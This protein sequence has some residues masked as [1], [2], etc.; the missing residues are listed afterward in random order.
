[1]R[2]PTQM[3][4]G[5]AET[6]EQMLIPRVKIGGIVGETDIDKINEVAFELYKEALSIVN[7]AAHLLDDA[8]SV[9]GGWPRNQAIC[10]GLMVRITKF[11]VV[12]TQLSAK[13]DRAEVVS[14]LNRS[15]MES[16]INLEFLVCTK[17][18]KY[19]DQFVK[20]SLGPERELFD[21]IKANVAA[22]G[23]E[24]WPIERRMLK[25][26]NAVCH[27]SGVKIEEVNRKYGDWGGGLRERLKALNKEER[28]VGAQRLPSHA[29]HG[30]WV[31]LYLHHLEHD[32]KTDVFSPDPKFSRVDER[33]LG[34]IAIFVLEATKPYLMRF[35]LEI[36]E[37][38]LLLERIDDMRNRIREVGAVHESL[39]SE[40][41]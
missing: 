37:T 10:A 26:I 28:Y 4:E 1:M 25:S 6:L 24:A 13:G 21:I 29:V 15:I 18:D 32:L 38:K 41:E 31:D 2:D 33:L 36:P 5:T 40:K 34:P 35:F 14:A 7:L 39:M 16:A 30:T 11:M 17:D 27:A 8:A 19:F 3:T 12:V 23:G 20:F 9:K 22:R